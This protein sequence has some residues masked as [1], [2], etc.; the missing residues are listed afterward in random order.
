VLGMSGQGGYVHRTVCPWCGLDCTRQI[1]EHVLTHLTNGH[2]PC[3]CPTFG[4]SS[5]RV[6]TWQGVKRHI[7]A[8]HQQ[9]AFRCS[10]CPSRFDNMEDLS[11]HLLTAHPQWIC[12]VCYLI[13]QTPLLCQQHVNEKHNH[14][15]HCKYC[16]GVFPDTEYRAHLINAHGHEVHPSRCSYC[17]YVAGG[18]QVNLHNMLRDH[19]HAIHLDLP[20]AE[21]KTEKIQITDAATRLQARISLIHSYQRVDGTE[22]SV[23]IQGQPPQGI[24]EEDD[25]DEFDPEQARRDAVVCQQMYEHIVEEAVDELLPVDAI[26]EGLL[27]PSQAIPTKRHIEIVDLCSDDDVETTHQTLSSPAQ[28]IPGNGNPDFIDLTQDESEPHDTSTGTTEKEALHAQANRLFRLLS[29]DD[30]KLIELFLYD[31]PAPLPSPSSHSTRVNGFSIDDEWIARLFTKL[32][33]DIKR[34]DPDTDVSLLVPPSGLSTD[35]VLFLL[36]WPSFTTRKPRYGN[37]ADLTN[38]CIRHVS[39][40]VGGLEGV[41]IMDRLLLRCQQVYHD[42]G[43]RKFTPEYDYPPAIQPLFQQFWIDVW[44]HASAKFCVL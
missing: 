37:V 18:P 30:Q 21:W 34:L 22:S 29:Q 38:P 13:F 4:C 12:S 26:D 28:A 16:T 40:A 42:N 36:H 24:D 31:L 43:L 2:L 8:H 17:P 27:V 3:P 6:K 32:I 25:E 11:R 41:L 1:Q 39:K 14:I 19:V 9:N 7:A 15:A 35:L 10:H 23:S 5:L 44:Q 20:I 33:Q